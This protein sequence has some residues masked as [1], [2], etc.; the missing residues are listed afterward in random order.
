MFSAEQLQKFAGKKRIIQQTFDEAVKENI[1][2]FEMEVRAQ[3][4]DLCHEFV[5]D[6]ATPKF[7]PMRKVS[8]SSS[9]LHSG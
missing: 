7:E 1:D 2:E 8:P 9:S 6:Q 5:S 3:T 4:N